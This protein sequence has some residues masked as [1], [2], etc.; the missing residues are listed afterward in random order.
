MSL[1]SKYFLFNFYLFFIF[2]CAYAWDAVVIYSQSLKEKHMLE[3]TAQADGILSAIA[4]PAK[5][6]A[7]KKK[8]AK[9]AKKATAK[10]PAAKKAKK[11]AKKKPAAKKKAAKKP[12]K[13][14]AAKK[15]AKKPA[16]KKAAKKAAKKPAKKK[17]AK[18]AAKKPA[19]KK[20][21]KKTAKKKSVK[22]PNDGAAVNLKVFT[23]T[24]SSKAEQSPASVK[25]GIEAMGSS[26]VNFAQ[27]QIE[28]TVLTAQQLLNCRSLEDLATVQ[29]KF[30]KQSFDR[31][32][33]QANKM[34]QSTANLAKT[35]AAP[36]S[37]RM[38]RFMYANR[39]A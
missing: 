15:V 34:A 32:V 28:E 24:A 22:K 30:V 10:K 1:A 27:D 13:K 6:P 12:A 7:A 3:E 39:T 38:E 37:D 4:A 5:K 17:V 25:K 20:A 2:S 23:T 14:K 36:L 26:L 35:A 31:L 21:A 8:K 33:K 29:T 16:K 19:K 11:A 9:K 18:K